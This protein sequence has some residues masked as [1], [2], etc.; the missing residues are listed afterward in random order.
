MIQ[1]DEHSK[2]ALYVPEGCAHGFYS[3]TDSVVHY[4]CTT[5]YDKDSDG[6]IFP[7]DPALNINWPEKSPIISGKDMRLPMME[8]YLRSRYGTK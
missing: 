5:L 2:K 8:Q 3:V 6:G 4:K 7:L 1:L